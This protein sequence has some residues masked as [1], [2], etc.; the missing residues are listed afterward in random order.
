MATRWTSLEGAILCLLL[1]PLFQQ[2]LVIAAGPHKAGTSTR[3]KRPNTMKAD[4]FHHLTDKLTHKIMKDIEKLK[5]E[6]PNWGKRKPEEEEEEEIDEENPPMTKCDF[7]CPEGLVQTKSPDFKMPEFTNCRKYDKTWDRIA[8]ASKCCAN[9]ERCYHTCKRERMLCDMEFGQ[10]M[11]SLCEELVEAGRIGSESVKQAC[12]SAMGLV[13][14]II[15]D[16]GCELYPKAQG[17]ACRCTEPEEEEE[18]GEEVMSNPFDSTMAKQNDN[19]SR[20]SS[21]HFAQS[22]VTGTSQQRRDEL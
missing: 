11:A 10:C 4:D 8:G 22:G 13:G 19:L 5:A 7:A 9:H 12:D 3:H 14:V 15:I 2:G 20:G 16:P 1:V 21:P 17:A 6:D 18:E